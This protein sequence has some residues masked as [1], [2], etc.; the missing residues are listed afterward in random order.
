MTGTIF[1]IGYG[2]KD[3]N[4]FLQE[5]KSFDINY[6]ADVRTKPYAKWNPAFNQDVLTFHL[7]SAGIRYVYMGDQLGG[8]P[9]DSSCYTNGHIDYAKIA[10]KDFFRAGLERLVVANTK[11]LR[12]AVMCSEGDPS[13]CHRS[14]LIGQE[15][16]KRHIMMQHIVGIG[17]AKSQLDVIYTLTKGTPTIDLFGEE[18]TF[19]SRKEYV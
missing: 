17:K 6:L 15:L 3:I 18:T 13:L 12:L 7:D 9:T 4:E 5:L 10:Q 14:K 19:M 16:L 11:G 8:M 2:N 1:S